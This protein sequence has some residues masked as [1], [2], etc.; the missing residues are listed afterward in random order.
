MVTIGMAD[1]VDDFLG[2]LASLVPNVDQQAQA[3]LEQ[4]LRSQWGGAE[5][6]VGKRLN[7]AT[8]QRILERGLQQR[9]QLGAIILGNKVGLGRSTLYEM[10]KKKS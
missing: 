7:P 1:I 4:D 9:Q 10:L 6:Y 2:R 5:T 3:R 8:R